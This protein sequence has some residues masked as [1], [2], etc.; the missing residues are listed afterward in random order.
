MYRM[1]MTR[2][3]RAEPTQAGQSIGQALKGEIV[4]IL[5]VS[6]GWSQIKL[7][8]IFGQP[9]GWVSSDAVEEV[10][11]GGY[12]LQS[13]DR[14]YFTR[15]CWWTAMTVGVNP[16]YL[17]AI[18]DLRSGT[19]AGKLASGVAE[20]GPFGFTAEEWASQAIDL[21]GGGAL[22]P[23][24]IHSWPDQILVFA[25]A[26]RKTT[27]AFGQTAPN[28]ILL[29]LS[30]L[31]D[32]QGAEN[33]LAGGA[34]SSTQADAW[35]ARF[36]SLLAPAGSILT[37]DALK[38]HF[39]LVLGAAFNNT[40]AIVEAVGIGIL[41]DPYKEKLTVSDPNSK[42]RPGKTG[43]Y[44]GEFLAKA[45]GIMRRLI[46]DFGFNSYQSAGIL[47]NIGH[48][49]GGFK[50]LR[51]IGS[52]S[53]Y[54]YCQWSKGRRVSFEKFCYDRGVSINSDV[55][56]YE[57]LRFELSNAYYSVNQ[58]LKKTADLRSATV[59]F[60]RDFEKPAP[61]TAALDRRLEW[62]QK[63]LDRYSELEKSGAVTPFP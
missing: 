55:G 37:G 1:A 33:L 45:P 2:L 56:N 46:D 9:V 60:M 49:C 59:L 24:A 40:A 44:D 10:S 36:G 48:E 31:L 52:G 50:M 26:A 23:S 35:L 11:E 18:A 25:S 57:Y 3:L 54:G 19:R 58:N 42:L 6:D 4:A 53:G 13:I 21:D 51:E 34:V 47:G 32:K 62:A 27:R 14:D 43:R 38:A 12:P 5:T 8:D 39:A 16:H 15:Q 63:A 17:V 41:D 22:P 7:V 29:F 61:E 20:Y 28:S 30:Q